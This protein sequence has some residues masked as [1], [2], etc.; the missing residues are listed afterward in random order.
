[1][2]DILIFAIDDAAL[3]VPLISDQSSRPFVDWLG[4]EKL[5]INLHIKGF[6]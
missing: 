4:V 3:G 6:T 1:M 2:S 5:L